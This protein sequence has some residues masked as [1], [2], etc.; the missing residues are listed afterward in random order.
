LC[1]S[2]SN[3]EQR[4][5]DLSTGRPAGLAWLDLSFFLLGDQ[6]GQVRP[7]APGRLFEVGRLELFL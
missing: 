1:Q 5:T 3:V 7:E 2:L 4:F 6:S